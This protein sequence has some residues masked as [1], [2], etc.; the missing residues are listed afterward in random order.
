MVI[1][2]NGPHLLAL[3]GSP[4][5]PHRDSDKQWKTQ[6]SK[7]NIA[8]IIFDFDDQILEVEAYDRSLSTTVNPY[9]TRMFVNRVPGTVKERY[10]LISHRSNKQVDKK[11][12]LFI[13]Y[14]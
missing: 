7:E 11:G 13:T 5:L 9:P 14:L 3:I 6:N 1:T 8:I 12:G 2:F 10:T 4:F